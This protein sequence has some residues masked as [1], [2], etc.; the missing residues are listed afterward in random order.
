MH[1]INF[2]LRILT[3]LFAVLVISNPAMANEKPDIFAQLGQTGVD[4]MDISQDEK[5][6]ISGSFKNIKLWE[7][8]TGREI[9]TFKGKA[10]IEFISFIPGDKTFLSLDYG[11]NVCTWDINTGKKINKFNAKRTI[12]TLGSVSYDGNY[13]RIVDGPFLTTVDVNRGVVTKTIRCVES[14]PAT[15]YAFWFGYTQ[16][17]TPNG[18]L[19]L[20]SAHVPSEELDKLLL[21]FDPLTGKIIRKYKGHKDLIDVI[22]I[23][24]DGSKALSGSRDRTVKYWDLKKGKE[25]ATFKGHRNPIYKIAFSPDGRYAL[26]GDANYD[27]DSNAKYIHKST[28]KLWDLKKKRNLHTF[29]QTSP[30]DSVKFSSNGRLAIAAVRGAGI[31]IWD[32]RTGEKIRELKG[33]AT[34]NNAMALSPDGRHLV[35]GSYDKQLS[36]WDIGSGKM[37]RSLPGHKGIVSS[38]CFSPDGRHVVSGSTDK[39]IRLWDLTNGKS[40]KTFSGHTAAV[41]GVTVSPDGKYALSYSRDKSVRLWD[42]AK[43]TEIKAFMFSDSINSAGFS[44]DGQ[45]IIVAYDSK[46]DDIKV[47]D[48][49]GK[50]AAFYK[51]VFISRY[52]TDGRYFLAES[53]EKQENEENKI[54]APETKESKK[55]LSKSRDEILVD[56]ASGEEL[57]SFKGSGS[58]VYISVAADR[59]L[60]LSRSYFDKE[61]RLVEASTGKEIRKFP[62]K[63][64]LLTPDG[65]KI[66]APS[67]K[68]LKLF[69]VETGNELLTMKGS[70]AGEISSFELSAKGGYAISGDITGEIQFWDISKAKLIK[71]IKGY[72]DEK[73]REPKFEAQYLKKLGEKDRMRYMRRHAVASVVFSPDNRYAASTDAYGLLKIWNLKSGNEVAS[74]KPGCQLRYCHEFNAGNYIDYG[75]GLF[76]FSPNGRYLTTGYS[77]LLESSTGRKIL[78][79]EFPTPGGYV[80]FSPDGRHLISGSHVW[81]ASTGKLINSYDIGKEVICLYSPDGK[82]IYAGGAS[83]QSNKNGSFYVIESE[84][85]KLVRKSRSSMDP[86]TFDLSSDKKL[87]LVLDST[88]PELSLWDVNSGKKLKT[89]PTTERS[90]KVFFTSNDRYAVTNNGVSATIWDMSKGKE[91]AQFISFKDGEWIT[92][93]PEGYFNASPNGAKHLNVRIGNN[94]YSV[95]NFYS[96]FYRPEL[97]Q[98]AL[99][100]KELPKGEN[101]GEILVKNP[102][103]S[104]RILSPE[105]GAVVD[106][107]SIDIT[108]KAVDNGG[109]IGDIN[110]YLNGSQVANDTRSIAIKGKETVNEKTLSFGVPLLEGQNE[111]RVIAFNSEGSM[112]SM[113]A[114]I[115]ITS[116]AVSGT[117]DIYAIV[118]GIN[119]YRN[120]NISLRYAVPDAKA[121]AETLKAVARPPL[122][123]NVHIKLLATSDETTKESIQRAFAGIRKKIRPNDI[124]VFYD[125]SHGVIDIVDEAEQYYLL[126]SNVLLLSSRH[127]GRDAM[128][129]KELIQLI[130]T[131]PAQ[132]KLI[133]LDTCH[134]GKAG[135]EI[136]IALLQQTRGLTE[137][138]AI[139]LLQRAVGSAVFSAASDT[140]QAIEGYRGHGLF[141]YAVIEGLKGGADLNK[142]GYVKISELQDYVEEKVVTLSEQVFKRQQI[143]TIQTGAN[144]PIGRIK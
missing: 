27:T 41:Y 44:A 10:S 8:A 67:G 49:K 98:M 106:K 108:I 99:A 94:V 5:Y 116:K 38:A 7:I 70:A 21:L 65:T 57:R 36:Y 17:I 104:V 138:T 78:E 121:F 42:I 109:G 3:V 45:Y 73:Q 115:T 107:E 84:S 37:I 46:F 20:S 80:A 24:P 79:F 95:D 50:E 77:G 55:L 123:E 102:A 139:K 110:V 59:D 54:F 128:S 30:I 43:G 81:D 56:I 85:G 132:K 92:I 39:T 6:L 142:D 13:L 111:I 118:A 144:F 130:G 136:A 69:D 48:R 16:A 15:A 125:A 60:I 105:T 122:F 33:N 71:R 137:S 90:S 86:Y 127:I 88:N 76:E 51:N 32:T 113:P 35:T 140:Q 25:I 117:P 89:F 97:V 62:L 120:K 74:S 141:T 64:G 96:R 52:S 31:K 14:G 135:K 68:T 131:I 143:P 101:I 114:I 23:S 83:I 22:A 1:K 12:G 103:P 82:Y 2:A 61:S 133:I 91:L 93:T 72:K 40:V 126:T 11:G 112:E 124:F 63:F 18:K 58:V 4:V 87:L 100:G 119:E 53:Y 75:R 19:V 26:S 28:V 129:Q 29:V 134:A 9:R 34:T 66:V 47:F